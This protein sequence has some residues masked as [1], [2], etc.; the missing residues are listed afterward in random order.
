MHL[1]RS[2]VTCAVTAPWNTPIMHLER[3]CLVVNVT[4]DDVAVDG[5]TL[6]GAV[7]TDTAAGDDADADDDDDRQ[8]CNDDWDDDVIFTA[9]GLC[10]T[11]VA[12]SRSGTNSPPA[13]SS[14]TS[15]KYVF[16]TSLDDA[17]ARH[18]DSYKYNY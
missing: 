3:T 4:P 11:T 7:D 10:A 8:P 9:M 14:I 16:D 15:R 12:G 17:L 6:T 18:T 2:V 5:E 13:D 1:W